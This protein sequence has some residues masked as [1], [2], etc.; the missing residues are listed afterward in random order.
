MEMTGIMDNAMMEMEIEFE[1]KQSQEAQPSRRSS[2]LKAK[3]GSSGEKRT[4]HGKRESEED[5]CTEALACCCACA[6]PI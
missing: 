1:I 2:N 4:N 6:Q 3:R 5:V